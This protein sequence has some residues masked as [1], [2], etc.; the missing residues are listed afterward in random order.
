MQ[1]IIQQLRYFN[2]VFEPSSEVIEDTIAASRYATKERR[3]QFLAG[4]Q[5]VREQL[6]NAT[7]IAAGSWRL[8]ADGHGRPHAVD[9][10]GQPGPDLSISHSGQFVASALTITGVVG[11]DLERPRTHRSTN[12]ISKAVF[13]TEEQ[14]VVEREGEPA[15]LRFWTLREAIGKAMGAGLRA[16]LAIDGAALVSIGQGVAV[17]RI[18]E[19]MWILGSRDLGEC[20]L[21]VAWRP[22]EE[23]NDAALDRLAGAL[24]KPRVMPLDP[25]CHVAA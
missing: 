23:H 4:R 21:S 10:D 14:R 5:L 16:G 17:L 2:A 7:G 8:V 13:S 18:R 19:Q 25:S 11:L 12:A 22:G 15:F 24:A 3:A 1:I 6:E 9:P 20:M